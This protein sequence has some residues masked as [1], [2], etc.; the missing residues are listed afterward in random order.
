MA[1]PRRRGRRRRRA[2]RTRPGCR[3]GAAPGR[4]RRRP[5]THPPASPR[6]P[7]P[8]GRRDPPAGPAPASRT[9]RPTTGRPGPSPSPRAGPIPRSARASARPPA[10]LFQSRGVRYVDGQS[11][12]RSPASISS[13]RRSSAWRHRNSAASATSPGSSIS[14]SVPGST[15]SRPVAGAR[16]AAQTSAAS[17]TDRAAARPFVASRRRRLRAK[18]D[19]IVGQAFRQAAG[20]PAKT[21]RDGRRRRP[22]AGGTR[23]PAGGSRV[24]TWPTVR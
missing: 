23:W 22:G 20:L 1:G 12:G 10:G 11:F 5:G 15:W 14:R 4:R 16:T 3:R 17:P 7:R 6:R 8:G 9:D 21:L 13:A 24:S 18:A 2:A 19:E